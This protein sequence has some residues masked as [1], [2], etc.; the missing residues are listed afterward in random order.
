MSSNPVTAL[1]L[2]HAHPG[3]ALTPD[4]ADAR[5]A[6]GTPLPPTWASQRR[7]VL[8]NISESL[9]SDIG[10]PSCTLARLGGHRGGVGVGVDLGAAGTSRRR[11]AGNLVRVVRRPVQMVRVVRYAQPAVVRRSATAPGT[12]NWGLSPVAG[13]RPMTCP[14]RFTGPA[15]S[16]PSGGGGPPPVRGPV[17]RLL[18]SG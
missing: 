8:P 12:G 4:P 14:Y 9:R 11:R 3:E 16:A 15:W 18:R 1:L 7:E 13:T 2:P 5:P 10:W 6:P 17:R